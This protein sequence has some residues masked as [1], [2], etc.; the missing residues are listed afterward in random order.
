MIK[1][2]VAGVFLGV[3]AVVAAL[4]VVPVVDQ[5]RER[6]IISVLPNGGNVEEFHINVPTDRVLIG[7]AAQDPPLPPDLDWPADPFL[8]GV[9]V[10]LFKIRNANDVVVGVASRLAASG[11]EPGDVI[12]WVLHL[13]ARGS[14][15]VTMDTAVSDGG[16]RTGNYRAGS[17]EFGRLRGRI[18]E[19]FV[20]DGAAQGEEP[21]GIIELR[22]MFVA[23]QDE[24]S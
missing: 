15:Y 7:T 24:S 18:T 3:A 2:L 4:F 19:R 17:S 20:A 8:A 11:D 16:Y 10:E 5:H 13:P 6:S 14:L 9:R 12:E 21:A 1:T 22:T 23:A